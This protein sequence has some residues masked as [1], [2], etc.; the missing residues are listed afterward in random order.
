M[1]IRD[2][3]NATND[4]SGYNDCG[5]V[6]IVHTKRNGTYQGLGILNRAT[7]RVGQVNCLLLVARGLGEEVRSD[8]AYFSAAII[9]TIFSSY[10]AN[11]GTTDAHSVVPMEADV[12]SVSM[13]SVEEKDVESLARNG[14]LTFDLVNNSIVHYD[15]ID[16]TMHNDA[17]TQHGAFRILQDVYHLYVT[18]TK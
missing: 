9:K 13:H 18:N 10:M 2:E 4:Y 16:E 12:P 17:L 8:P 14:I 3:H 7:G 11:F 1:A 5:I 6:N 15:V